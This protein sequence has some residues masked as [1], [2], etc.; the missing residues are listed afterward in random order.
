MTAKCLNE[1][2]LAY[3]IQWNIKFMNS[4]E[5]LILRLQYTQSGVGTE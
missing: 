2:F 5:I 4:W 3:M 1:L